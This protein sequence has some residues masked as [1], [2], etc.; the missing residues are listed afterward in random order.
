MLIYDLAAVGAAV[1]WAIGGV[2]GASPAR[3]FG[4]I[5]FNRLRLSLLTVI[6]GGASLFVGDWGSLS[7]ANAGA[8]SL[9]TIAGV[10]LGDVL[11]FAAMNRLGPR[12]TAL[13]FATHSVFSVLLGVLLLGEHLSLKAILG[14]VMVFGGVLLAIA[15]G[16]KDGNTHHWEQS[17]GLKLGVALG[18][19]A[20]ICQALGTFFAKP[21]IAG[22]LD[23]FIASTLRMAIACSAQWLLWASGSH[24]TRM[25]H[26]PNARMLGM[27]ALN[28][29]I[30]LGLGMLLIMVALQ[31]GDVATVGML[32]ALSPVLILPLLWLV[33]RQRPSLSGWLGAAISVAG[34]ML[35]ISRH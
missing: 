34:T 33:T 12:R 25:H 30:G 11:F 28:G 2:L 29:L 17:H 23:P 26:A 13:L 16:R 32:S 31:Q 20:A 35:I 8:I 4:P 10:F 27:L 22:G 3:H 6:L 9:S 19:M 18:L 15:F 21:A 24:A 5:A 7:L 1:C 14:S